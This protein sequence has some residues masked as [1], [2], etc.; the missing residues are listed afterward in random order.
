MLR[1]LDNKTGLVALGL[2]DWSM[3]SRALIGSGPSH[4]ALDMA[5]LLRMSISDKNDKIPGRMVEI[6][7]KPARNT[8]TI[9]SLSFERLE[10][11]AY[12]FRMVIRNMI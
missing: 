10:I 6:W 3:Q 5:D 8:L 2:T 11:T 12:I 4:V 7:V 1:E 9:D